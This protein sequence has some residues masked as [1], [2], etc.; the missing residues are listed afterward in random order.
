MPSW[1]AKNRAPGVVMHLRFN[2]AAPV[3]RLVWSPPDSH[4]TP[5]CSFC[6]SFIPADCVPLIMWNKENACVH[7][8]DEC[9]EKYFEVVK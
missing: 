6:Q 4:I 5:F 3:S 2:A 1:N 8:C 7:F 9:V